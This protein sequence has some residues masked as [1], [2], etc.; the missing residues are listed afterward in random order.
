MNR[1]ISK[2]LSYLQDELTKSFKLMFKREIV[3]GRYTTVYY[4]IDIGSIKNNVMK[5]NSER[6]LRII[7]DPYFLGVKT[8]NT[9]K[10]EHDK[11][12]LSVTYNEEKYYEEFIK[13]HDKYKKIQD[14]VKGLGR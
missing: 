8:E 12:V 5:V 10:R 2:N 13:N 4:R 3:K 6:I 1:S 7:K 9:Y 11:M 14:Y